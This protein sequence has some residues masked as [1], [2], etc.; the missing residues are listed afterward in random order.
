MARDGEHSVEA[1]NCKWAIE[2]MEKGRTILNKYCDDD[3]NVMQMYKK[4]SEEADVSQI[5]RNTVVK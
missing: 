3:T 5:N 4:A 1:S 2:E